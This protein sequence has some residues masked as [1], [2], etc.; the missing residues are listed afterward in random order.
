MVE[1]NTLSDEQKLAF[2]LICR[3]IIHFDPNRDRNPL[4]LDANGGSGKSTLIRCVSSYLKEYVTHTVTAFTGRACSQI[5]KNGISN[6]HTSHSIM[7]K[8]VTDF[9]GNLI[10][11]EDRTKDEILS[12]VGQAVIV[13]EGSM[14]PCDMYTMLMNLG[15]PIIIVGDTGQLES[16]EPTST[17]GFS[18]MEVEEGKKITL[19][20]NFRQEQGSAIADLCMH[21]RDNNSIPRRKAHDLKM[22]LKSQ[23]FKLRYHIDNQFD[24]IICGTN[25]TRKKMNDLIRHARGFNNE[26][27]EQGEIVICKR[28]D[29][30]NNIKINNGE[31]YRVEGSFNDDEVGTYYLTG[32]DNDKKITVRVPNETWITEQT[33]RKLKGKPVQKFAFGYAMTCHAAQGSQF[34]N[35]LYIDED[36][37]FFLNQQKFRY[38]AVSRAA[39]SLTIAI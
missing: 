6:V 22:V 29:I 12:T 15:I 24:A 32:I 19:S 1:F 3:H 5:A 36:V 17:Q 23:V 7:K 38:T 16:I 4:I 37:S 35:L 2:H 18:A 20:R 14:F 8:P 25:K 39:K 31:L 11:W 10:S 33:D 13:D 30:V 9:E 28:N 26:T 34:D 27:P 21:L